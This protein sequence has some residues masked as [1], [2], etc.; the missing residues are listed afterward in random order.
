[1]ASGGGSAPLTEAERRAQQEREFGLP[2]HETEEAKS[3]I[4]EI[5]VEIAST[6][7]ASGGKLRFV[8]SE[9]AV[10]EQTEGAPVSPPKP[11][12]TV[13]IKRNFM[14]GNVCKIGEWTNM[15]CRRVR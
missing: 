15:R 6:G 13:T 2:E 9:G 1:M 3:E 14:G 4:G 10:W 7:V 8:T 12:T 5:T 11:G